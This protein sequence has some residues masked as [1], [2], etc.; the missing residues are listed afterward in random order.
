MILIEV[1]I[2]FAPELGVIS[3]AS[4]VLTDLC[5]A[6]TSVGTVVLFLNL[7]AIHRRDPVFDSWRARR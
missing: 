2:M 6:F 5:F 4:S 1:G 7:D 3:F